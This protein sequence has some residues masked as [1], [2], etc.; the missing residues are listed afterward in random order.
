M[1][2]QVRQ[3]TTGLRGALLNTARNVPVSDLSDVPISFQ[4]NEFSLTSTLVSD[5]AFQR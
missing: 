3:R 2:R 5:Q 1:T 4:V